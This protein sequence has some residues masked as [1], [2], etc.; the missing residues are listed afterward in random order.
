VQSAA[1]VLASVA[2]V[3]DVYTKRIPNVLTFGGAALALICHTW[4]HGLAGL[5][6]SSAGLGVG[7]A[8]F[9]PM[10]LLG[11]MGA[12]DVKLLGAVGAWLGPMGALW[13]GFMSVMAGGLLALVVAVKT[14][15]LRRALQNLWGLLLF[16]RAAGIQ[17][18]PS[19]TLESSKGPRV[20]YGLAIAAGTLAT[21]LWK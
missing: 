17:P 4:L 3:V 13:T 10:F 15:Y 19:L 18:L 2:A 12:G 14:R 20:A 5:G 1:L 11:G 16:W 7:L 8:L 6:E 21:V 9:L